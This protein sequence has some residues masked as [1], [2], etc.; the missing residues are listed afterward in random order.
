VTSF[1]FIYTQNV[2][3]GVCLSQRYMTR[4]ET[5]QKINLNQAQNSYFQK[6][7]EKNCLNS[8]VLWHVSKKISP[9]H[10]V[11]LGPCPS[12]ASFGSQHSGHVRCSWSVVFIGVRC[13]SMYDGSAFCIC[14]AHSADIIT[15]QERISEFLP[16][17]SKFRAL[18]RMSTC[19]VN[20]RSRGKRCG[21][22][23]IVFVLYT[24]IT[25]IITG[26]A[27]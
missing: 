25:V 23:W 13:H 8:P 5:V 20:E 21:G 4:S 2:V 7:L 10:W 27:C 22:L 3:L 18:E 16:R 9:Q 24:V 19:G 15:F 17:R 11:I 1:H 26:C 14:P 12:Y 6:E